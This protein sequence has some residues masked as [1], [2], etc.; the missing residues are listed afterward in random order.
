VTVCFLAEKPLPCHDLGRGKPGIISIA[1]FPYWVDC[2]WKISFAYP[3]SSAPLGT[4]LQ[5]INMITYCK[6]YTF[7]TA[8]T[9]N[10]LSA[11]KYCMTQL[12]PEVTK[13]KWWQVN[14]DY[15]SVH[16]KC[17][18]GSS[19]GIATDYGL[20]G[21]GIES[22]WGEIFCTC[23][24][25]PWGPHSLLYNGYQVFPGGKV[26]FGRAADHSPPSSAEVMEE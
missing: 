13:Q 8:P 4:S 19:V 12:R 7:T 24:D 3:H 5:L 23:P 15:G 17:G 16:V 20:D 10:H 18:P 26:R 25:R 22:Q 9:T 14:F 21:P 2:G 11:H 1:P 6:S